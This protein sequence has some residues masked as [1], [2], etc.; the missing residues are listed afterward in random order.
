MII[1]VT[2]TVNKSTLVG[3]KGNTNGTGNMAVFAASPNNYVK[4]NGNIIM[5][6]RDTVAI[7]SDNTKVDLNGKLD[8]KLKP[9][10]QEKYSNLC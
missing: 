8:I 4:V 10:Q 9:N 7:Y 2:L 3:D 6:T 5:D 1:Q